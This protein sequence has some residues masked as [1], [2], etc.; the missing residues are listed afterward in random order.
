MTKGKSYLRNLVAFYN[1]VTAAVDEGRA[2][3][4]IYMDLCKAVDTVLQDILFCKVKRCGFN[5]WTFQ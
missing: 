1:G 4:I 2:Q 5:G 3:D